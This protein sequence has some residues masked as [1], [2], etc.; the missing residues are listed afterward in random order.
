M[1][2]TREKLIE[3]CKKGRVKYNLWGDR[4]SHSAQSSLM[5]T[6]LLLESNCKFRVLTDSN[7]RICTDKQTIWI[8]IYYDDWENGENW[9]TSYLPTEKRLKEN[10]DGD[11][12]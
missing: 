6:Q 5:M 11:W 9:H 4:D 3:I 2:Y 8:E 7:E 10:K 12:Y 1:E